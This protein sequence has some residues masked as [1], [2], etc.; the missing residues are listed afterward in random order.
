MVNS[1]EIEFFEKQDDELIHF[2]AKKISEGN[3]V[4][5]FQDKMEFGPRALGNR[6]ILCDPRNNNMQNILNLKIKRRESFRPFAPSIL[7][8]EV[9]NWF[10]EKAYA[11][12]MSEVF[13]IKK[14]KQKLIPAVTHV[15]GTGRLQTVRKEINKKYYDLIHKF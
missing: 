10:D 7:E 3:V 13:G 8:E 14:D 11:F 4:G 5:W 1:N 15:D 6:S 12:Y 2:I 9:D